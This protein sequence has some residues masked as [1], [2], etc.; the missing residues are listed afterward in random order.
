MK[1]STLLGSGKNECDSSRDGLDGKVSTERNYWHS[2]PFLATPRDFEGANPRP[3]GAP[4]AK[5]AFDCE[6]D[7]RRGAGR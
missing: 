4:R 6:G 1:D 7:A 2:Q 3:T 5:L